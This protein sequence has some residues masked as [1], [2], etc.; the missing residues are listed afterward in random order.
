M[1][2]ALGQPVFVSYLNNA[3]GPLRLFVLGGLPVCSFSR[4]AIR[5]CCS[6]SR[7]RKAREISV[8]LN[9]DSEYRFCR[10]GLMEEAM[11]ST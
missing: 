1:T 10:Y 11:K 8:R 7:R 3:R 9:L 5:V 6:I 4:P 2:D